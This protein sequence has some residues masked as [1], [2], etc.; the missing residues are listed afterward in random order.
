MKKYLPVATL[1]VALLS[2]SQV[3][4]QGTGEAVVDTCPEGSFSVLCNSQGGGR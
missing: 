3:S 1:S 2:V 4:V